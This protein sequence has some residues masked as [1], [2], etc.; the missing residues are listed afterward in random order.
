MITRADEQ[1]SG[2]NMQRGCFGRRMPGQSLQQRRR[3]PE[4]SSGR[5][6]T[7]STD[8]ISTVEH[9]NVGWWT[10]VVRR[11]A[12]SRSVD[13]ISS[14]P[15]GLQ[16]LV[17]RTHTMPRA[18]F[19]RT[20]PY[21]GASAQRNDAA[22]A[23]S[24]ATQQRAACGLMIRPLACNRCFI[25]AVCGDHLRPPSPKKRR[26]ITNS[27]SSDLGDHNI[28]QFFFGA[29]GPAAVLIHT[30]EVV[31]AA[32][33]ARR[34]RNDHIL[35]VGIGTSFPGIR[36]EQMRTTPPIHTCI[37]I[38]RGHA[39]FSQFYPLRI[40]CHDFL[41]HT[42]LSGRIPRRTRMNHGYRARSRHSTMSLV[43][44]THAPSRSVIFIEALLLWEEHDSFDLLAASPSYDP[45][46]QPWCST[47]Q[48]AG[49][50]HSNTPPP[51]F[52]IAAFIFGEAEQAAALGPRFSATP[53]WNQHSNIRSNHVWF[54]L[55]CLG[56]PTTTTTRTPSHFRL[57]GELT[58][59]YGSPP[60]KTSGGMRLHIAPNET[61]IRVDL[62]A[63]SLP[64]NLI[65]PVP[66]RNHPS[67]NCATVG[68]LK[69]EV[70]VHR[71]VVSLFAII[72]VSGTV[73]PLL[74]D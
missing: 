63:P 41:F 20:V 12:K 11:T 72:S 32:G 13:E 7:W 57:R 71:V 26:R 30:R 38:P 22:I 25:Q 61:C 39:G 52:C 31:A 21:R 24:A 1:A 28:G 54:I 65:V 18:K 66:H 43:N 19:A 53:R 29:N 3:T 37:S 44:K 36:S 67:R 64:T 46:S 14:R 74:L 40:T 8:T 42:V 33:M 68:C 55:A 27:T 35:R 56:C 16:L 2:S 58:N 48:Y 70:V 23:L 6:V 17:S 45:T 15:H 4:K 49:Q 69:V 62:T 73:I 59:T 9:G 60:S 50:L 10:P 5:N 34:V 47:F 51:H